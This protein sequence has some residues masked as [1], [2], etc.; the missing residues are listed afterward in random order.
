MERV[1]IAC[2]EKLNLVRIVRIGGVRKIE[3]LSMRALR[4]VFGFLDDPRTVLALRGGND[5][6]ASSLMVGLVGKI[7]VGNWASVK[8]ASLRRVPTSYVVLD[9]SVDIERAIGL[10]HDGTCRFAI[11]D[12][13][14]FAPASVSRL[15]KHNLSSLPLIHVN[16]A[17]G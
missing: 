3:S 17:Y 2:C 6:R 11:I 7:R 10:L 1:T 8:S 4:Q 9:P 5:D 12:R 16:R 15:S 14:K 13:L